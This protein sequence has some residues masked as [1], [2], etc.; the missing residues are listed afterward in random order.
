MSKKSTKSTKTPA[1]QTQRQK[2]L[3]VKIKSAI[4]AGARSES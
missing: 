4:K 2:A 3:K 1:A